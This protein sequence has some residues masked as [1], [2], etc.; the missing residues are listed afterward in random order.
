MVTSSELEEVLAI[1]HRLLVFAH[2][3]VVREIPADDPEF[4]VDA[5]VHHGFSS[6]ENHEPVH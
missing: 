6:G 1:A 4:T 2:G 5:V 3:R